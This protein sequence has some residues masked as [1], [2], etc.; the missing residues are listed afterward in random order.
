M[1]AVAAAAAAAVAAAADGGCSNREQKRNR[2]R[3]RILKPYVYPTMS[4]NKLVKALLDAATITGLV[5]GIGWIGKK[6]IK[7]NLTSDPSASPMNYVKFTAVMASLTN[8]HREQ[9]HQWQ[10]LQ[11]QRRRQWLQQR[12][13]AAQT[14]N[15]NENDGEDE[16]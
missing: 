1:A 8:I 14:E 6:V 16:S 2:W 4:D 15:K 11:Q 12:M 13:A 5:A 3:G 7:E 10:R 9:L